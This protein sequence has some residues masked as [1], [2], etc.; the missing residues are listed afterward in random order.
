MC[1]DSERSLTRSDHGAPLPKCNA[2]A[3]ASCRPP[4]LMFYRPGVIRI[5]STIRF[6]NRPVSA[7]Y[8]S[9]SA[10]S[11]NFFPSR[12]DNLEDKSRFVYVLV[13]LGNKGRVKCWIGTVAPA[14][15]A[16]DRWGYGTVA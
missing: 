8:Q 16:P 14:P 7:N 4:P 12:P 10:D 13:H 6:Q 5:W 11:V 3:G 2:V 15:S 9:E 1:K